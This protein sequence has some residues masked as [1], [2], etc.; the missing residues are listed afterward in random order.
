MVNGKW[1]CNCNVCVSVRMCTHVYVCVRMCMS[2]VP[3]VVCLRFG[4]LSCPCL[5]CF[6]VCGG[7][8]CILS[9]TAVKRRGA[10]ATPCTHERHFG[11]P[12]GV[13]GGTQKQTRL[14]QTHI[15]GTTRVTCSVYHTT[16]QW[17]RRGESALWSVVVSVSVL[18]LRVR[19]I[20]VHTA[21][22]VV[23]WV[24]GVSP[25]PPPSSPCL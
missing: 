13:D 3:G 18:L 2:A 5:C 19:G 10:A 11:R 9:Q 1:Y 22:S 21:V 8:L 6:H 14:R 17:S 4:L 25:F 23:C 16:T 20:S 12:V 24:P 15:R 7:L